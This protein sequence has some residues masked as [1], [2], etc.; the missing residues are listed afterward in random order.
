[1]NNIDNNR[2]VIKKLGKRFSGSW[3]KVNTQKLK[4]MANKG[5]RKCQANQKI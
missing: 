5:V 1:M 4:R 2:S 3:S